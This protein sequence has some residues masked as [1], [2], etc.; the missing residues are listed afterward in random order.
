MAYPAEIKT[1]GYI[2]NAVTVNATT[3]SD[4][5]NIERAKTV[6]LDVFIDNTDAVGTLTVEVCNDLNRD[7]PNWVPVVLASGASSVSVTSGTNVNAFYNLQ[8]LGAKYL[9]VLYT[10]TSGSGVATMVAHV[11]KD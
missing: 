4:V 5:L 1:G 8:N 11:K 7:T 3:R 10:R 6:G 2:M 9:S